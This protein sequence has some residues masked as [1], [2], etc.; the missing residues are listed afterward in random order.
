MVSS[1]TKDIKIAVILNVFKRVEHLKLQLESIE[2]Q[3]IKPSQVFVWQNSID[4]IK[5]DKNLQ[6]KFNLIKSSQN[7]GVW[8]RFSF[9]LN[10][11]CDYICI[12]DDDTIPGNK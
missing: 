6:S 5:I 12:F 4:G 11:D 9:A 7:L 3:T 10:I 2:N 8:A 1:N